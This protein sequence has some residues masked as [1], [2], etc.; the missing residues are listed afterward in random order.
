MIVALLF[1]LVV[2][3]AILAAIVLIGRGRSGTRITGPVD[4]PIDYDN[5]YGSATYLWTTKRDP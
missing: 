3:A 1:V 2:F 4:R 5:P